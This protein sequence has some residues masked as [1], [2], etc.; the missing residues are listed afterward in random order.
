MNRATK[1]HLLGLLAGL[2]LAAAL[3]LSAML[4]TGAWLKIAESQTSSEGV[5]DTTSLEKT[6]TAVVTASFSLK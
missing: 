1:P 4:V 3:I 2:F 6:V 5:N